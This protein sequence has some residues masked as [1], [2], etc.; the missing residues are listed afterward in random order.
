MAESIYTKEEVN[1]ARL[2]ALLINEGT[3]A[4]RQK[5]TEELNRQKI[6]LDTFLGKKKSNLE[7]LLKQ[8]RLFPEQYALMYPSANLDR[9]DLELLM[10]LLEQLSGKTLSKAKPPASDGEDAVRT[11]IQET[12]QEKRTSLN[13]FLKTKK[14][15]MTK[16]KNRDSLHRRHYELLYPTSADL[17]TFDLTLLILLFKVLSINAFPT[18]E[19]SGTDVSLEADLDRMRRMRNKIYGH[20]KGTGV[21]DD[22]FEKQWTTISTVLVRLGVK[23]KRISK[24]KRDAITT[25]DMETFKK[26]LVEVMENDMGDLI[27]LQHTILSEMKEGRLGNETLAT[28]LNETG[29]KIE[30]C[31]KMVGYLVTAV[32]KQSTCLPAMIEKINTDQTKQI[33]EVLEML[34]EIR[35]ECVNAKHVIPM[36]TFIAETPSLSEMSTIYK[37]HPDAFKML[38]IS[39]PEQNETQRSLDR[40]CKVLGHCKWNIVL[41]MNEHS[42]SKQGIYDRVTSAFTKHTDLI[43]VTYDDIEKL[44]EEDQRNVAQG[45]R[46]LWIFANGC[47]TSQCPPSNARFSKVL[48]EFAPLLYNIL[49][50]TLEIQPVVCTT[51]TMTYATW[52][53]VC[54]LTE[55]IREICESADKE[56]NYKATKFIDVHTGEDTQTEMCRDESCDVHIVAPMEQLTTCFENTFGSPT[57]GMKYWYPGVKGLCSLESDEMAAFSSC[58]TLYHRD[59]GHFEKD[60]SAEQVEE[61]IQNMKTK[62]LRGEKITPEALYIQESGQDTT[63]VKR[64]EMTELKENVETILEEREHKSK[65][66]VAPVTTFN[67]FHDVSGGGTTCGRFLLY[68][69]RDRYPCIEIGQTN[70]PKLRDK[71]NYIYR[72]SKKTL[73]IVID[74]SKDSCDEIETFTNMLNNDFTKALVVIIRPNQYHKHSDRTLYVGSKIENPSDLNAFRKLY[75]HQMKKD[76]KVRKVFLFG[77]LAFTEQYKKLKETV[78]ACLRNTDENQLRV[79]R[80]ACLLWKYSH[81]PVPMKTLVKL[82]PQR[83]ELVSNEDELLDELG[84]GSDLLVGTGRGI[85]PAHICVVNALV[86][87]A[88]EHLITTFVDDMA[89][90]VKKDDSAK[91]QTT[92][93]LYA[94]FIERALKVDKYWSEFMVDLIKSRDVEYGGSVLKQFIELT[95]GATMQP[96]LKALFARYLMYKLEKP[97]DSVNMAKESLAL[98]QDE[99]VVNTTVK[100][101]SLLTTYG[102]LVREKVKKKFAD[103]D[104]TVRKT[105]EELDLA[106][107]DMRE[108]ICSYQKAQLCKNRLQQ[109]DSRPFVLEAKARYEI[110]LLFFKHKCNKDHAK[111]TKFVENTTIDLLRE[112]EGKAMKILDDLNL[113][114]K[115]DEVSQQNITT[116]EELETKFGLLRL[117]AD[118]STMKPILTIPPNVPCDVAEIVRHWTGQRRPWSDLSVDD[119]VIIF[120]KL[121][122]RMTLPNA[123]AK[124]Y[125]DI[126]TAMICLRSRKKQSLRYKKY[127]MYYARECADLWKHKFKEDFDAWFMHGVLTLLIGLEK[128]SVAEI[129]EALL[130]L[131][132]CQQI[133]KQRDSVKGFRGRRYI[134]G[135][136]Q[137]LEKLVRYTPD[138]AKGELERFIGRRKQTEIVVDGFEYTLKVKLPKWEDT[139]VYLQEKLVQF[140]MVLARDNLLAVNVEKYTFPETE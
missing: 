87:C 112:S 75:H 31:R 5:F 23:K 128:K 108:A 99:S 76:V 88:D 29:S 138:M 67:L 34:E 131:Q 43:T 30:D 89:V 137:G 13:E 28:Q 116:K 86:E 111:L 91:R 15:N 126:I 140:N 25:D 81:S 119:L 22:V 104:A 90:L 62:F 130:S 80:L 85:K 32:G 41:D 10:F 61:V 73:L 60:K 44:T 120:E 1:G 35:I 12:L 134:V 93:I 132:R 82:M 7:S 6:T 2:A 3:E 123:L 84:G 53:P 59:I 66:P 77:L 97:E 114:R 103:A 72:S 56:I 106:V 8:K 39:A 124:N 122:E 121:D 48:T 26:R 33:N 71:L 9:F 11:K 50:S 115:R 63:F 96:H 109:F 107:S 94:I 100:D 133:C 17:E 40:F 79:I 18:S 57:E 70:I 74:D 69:L 127:N 55:R 105:N 58:M 95:P 102:N 27:A 68:S 136:G 139:P 117:R 101:S 52:K 16:L 118:T 98:K 24:W 113:Y 110:L 38:T 37:A 83:S 92:V 51:I 125:E 64:H 14:K 54:R 19:P 42:Q 49:R 47:S 65:N 36:Q 45:R 4:V 135:E 21:D 78:Q 129:N 46:S 20:V